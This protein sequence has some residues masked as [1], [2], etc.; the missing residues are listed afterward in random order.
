MLIVED[1]GTIAL[2]LEDMLEELGCMV[3]LSAARLVQAWAALEAASFDFAVLDVNIAGETSFDFARALAER[4]IPFVF[5]T[6][7]GSGGLPPDLQGARVLAKPFTPDALL[8]AGRA[9]LDASG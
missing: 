5:S 3:A 7:Y 8:R 1:E 9:A 2:M 6:G 4:R